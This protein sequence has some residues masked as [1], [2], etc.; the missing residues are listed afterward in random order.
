MQPNREAIVGRRVVVLGAG[1]FLVFVAYSSAQLLQTSVNGSKGMLCLFSVYATFAAASL[2]APV[3]VSWLGPTTLLPLSALGYATMTAANIRPVAELLLPSCVVVGACAATLWSAQ[4]VYIGAS[5]VALSRA[6]GRQLTDCTS[7]LNTR[8]YSAFMVSGAVSGLFSTTVMSSGAP[9]AVVLLFSLLWCVCMGGVCLLA[10]V[11]LPDDPSSRIVAAPG[12]K[13]AGRAL[14]RLE[15][16][17]T[18]LA[19]SVAAAFWTD[20]LVVGDTACEAIAPEPAIGAAGVDTTVSAQAPAAPALASAPAPS[21]P[22]LF[23]MARFLATNERIRFLLPAMVLSGAGGGFYNGAFIGSVVARGIGAANVGLIGCVYALTSS[24]ASS[25]VW[26]PLSQRPGFGRRYGFAFAV[27]GYAAWYAAAAAGIALMP[28]PSAAAAA[29]VDA[30]AP[31]SPLVFAAH[32]AGA[33]AHGFFDPVLSSFIPATLQTFFPSGKEAL[34]AMSS[35][36]V[37]YSLGCAGQSLLSYALTDSGA[38]RLAEQSAVLALV[39]CVAGASLFHLNAR[40]CKIDLVTA[41]AGGAAATGV[42]SIST[43]SSDAEVKV[44][45]ASVGAT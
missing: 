38:P 41:D 31:V 34:C 14:A 12:S 17:A 33:I 28:P 36:R 26:A 40:V 21:R 32:V 3:L 9:T 5:A 11:P 23:F 20:E 42:A 29:T 24:L 39:A 22:T 10:A 18:R 25:L 27:V 7:A 43:T 2:Y 45:R 30:S 37:V 44:R 15:G 19:D 1:F 35:V 6:T 16:D 8:F 4:A 13:T